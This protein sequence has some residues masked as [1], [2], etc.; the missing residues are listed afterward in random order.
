MAG[1]D[2]ETHLQG[3]LGGGREAGQH[4]VLTPGP[5]SAGKGLRIE[6]DA[7]RAQLGHGGHRGRVGVHEEADANAQVLGFL[8]Q[9]LEPFGILRQLRDGHPRSGAQIA[10][11]LGITRSAVWHQVERLRQEGVAI[12]AVS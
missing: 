12:Y 8:D 1:V 4:G 11:E 3:G 9:R 7:S 10:R 2:A 5:E 6:L